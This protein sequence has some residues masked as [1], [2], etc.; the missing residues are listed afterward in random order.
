VGNNMNMVDAADFF[1]A[2]GAK[3]AVPLHTG[4]FDELSGADFPVENKA[5]PEI[6]K[7]IKL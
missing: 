2:T 5:V 6:Y 7:E 1:R 3:I 4:M